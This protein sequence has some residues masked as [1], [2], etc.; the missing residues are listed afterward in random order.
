MISDPF[1]FSAAN[2]TM[3]A[4]EAIYEIPAQVGLADRGRIPSQ[5]MAGSAGSFHH[6]RMKHCP[7]GGR[8]KIAVSKLIPKIPMDCTN[9]YSKGQLRVH[10]KALLDIGFLASEPVFEGRGD[11]LSVTYCRT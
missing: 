10:H 11:L 8:Y 3:S 4:S 5:R 6:P 1:P 9:K 2:A 7:P